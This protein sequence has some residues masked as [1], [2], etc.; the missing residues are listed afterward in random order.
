MKLVIKPV[1]AT[2]SLM[3]FLEGKKVITRICPGHDQI[4]THGNCR[5]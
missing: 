2:E 5:D 3:A 4:Y 1:K